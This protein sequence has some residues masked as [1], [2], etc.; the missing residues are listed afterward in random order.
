MSP[1]RHAGVRIP[2]SPWRRA[3]QRRR[4]ALGLLVLVPTA[5]ATSLM[6]AVLPDAG[7]DALRMA[8]SLVFGA[9]FG[10]IS[11][12]FWTGLVGF[13]VLLGR[14]RFAISRAAEAAA[15]RIP[16]DARTA[17]VIPICEEPVERVFAGLRAVHRSLEGTGHLDH[18]HF[19]V[20]S[21]SSDPD[22]WVA[23]EAAW[24][25]WC[26][27][28]NGLGRIFY[29][30]RRV[31]LARKAGNVADF[32]RRW[33]RDYRYMVVLDAD[34]LMA[35]DALVRLVRLMEARADVAVIQTVPAAVRRGSLFGRVQQFGN[36]LYGTMFAAGLHYWQLGEA[37]YWGHNAIVRVA[38][39]M[40]HCALPTLAGRPPL[41][42]D[43][44]SHDFVEAA[45][46]G[47]AGWGL[48]L[49][50][51]LCGSYE[52]TPGTLLE[53]MQRD[54]RW[55]RGNLQH[56]RLLA[57]D[58]LSSSHRALLLNGALSYGSAALW[59]VFLALGTAVAVRQAIVEPQY[60]P[61]GR[62]LFPEW[63]AYRPGWALALAAVTFAVLL[64]PKLLGT[65]RALTRDRARA[66]GGPARLLLGVGI[67][68]L[69]SS[70]LA[71]IRMVFHT[72]FVLSNLL[73]RETPWRSPGRADRETSWREALA[74]HG[75]DSV[76]AG[77]WGLGLF[78]LHP[79]YFFWT[80][81]VVGAL[82]LA[83]PLSVLA[84]RVGPGAWTLRRGLLCTP[85]EAEPPK[86]LRDLESLEARAPEPAAHGGGFGR[87][88][89]DPYANALHRALLRER[90]SL[91]PSIRAARR[92]LA[93]R[94]LAGGADAL[95]ASQQDVLLADPE[96]MD[97]LHGAAWAAW[98]LE[99]LTGA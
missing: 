54:H 27:E 21:D 74:H 40:E 64:A 84:S 80:L 91:A 37:P 92:A 79:E 95:T 51:D 48:W 46:L 3:A 85:E 8:I 98:P 87:T 78:W 69:V 44:W 53:E 4:T 49:A 2:S 89:V 81:P 30:R 99:R 19:F 23:E 33:G 29:R 22:T 90:R 94:A 72:R 36:S 26:R 58:G 11:I 62:S 20:L 38:P 67:E 57:I 50:Y 17:I 32:C 76:A 35:G 83:V 6:H 77:A 47:R 70:V 12:G 34:S 93:A 24:A 16:D 96:Q 7:G 73:G 88:V 39:F 82:L 52:E 42:G 59:F 15:A 97:A 41:G 66:W 86:V 68:F 10:W 65:A 55:C 1:R 25:A 31:R 5:A 45:L 63:P 13:G 43:I 18:F 71:P 9:L 75:L 14:D 56:L 60:F 61:A 28:V